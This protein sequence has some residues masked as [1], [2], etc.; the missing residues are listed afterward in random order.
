MTADTIDF[1]FHLLQEQANACKA[2]TDTAEV[3]FQADPAGNRDA[4]LDALAEELKTRRALE[5]F[6]DTYYGDGT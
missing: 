4:Y 1:I 5:E 2:E 6:H 3:A